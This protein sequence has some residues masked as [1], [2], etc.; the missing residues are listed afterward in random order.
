MVVLA[1]LAEGKKDP[2]VS[3]WAPMST[4]LWTML[5][6]RGP[7][8]VLSPPFLMALADYWLLCGFVL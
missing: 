7:P 2:Q 8:Y 5:I 6:I 4:K 3:L 1:T